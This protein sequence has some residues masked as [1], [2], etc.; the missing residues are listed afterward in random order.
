MAKRDL[1]GVGERKIYDFLGELEAELE[2]DLPFYP[3][4]YWVGR[5]ADFGALAKLGL[6]K[7]EVGEK[8]SRISYF[9]P[10]KRTVLLR[11]LD[12]EDMAEEAGH[13]VHWTLTPTKFPEKLNRRNV[14]LLMFSEAI[15]YFCS[16]L[17]VPERR[18]TFQGYKDLLLLPEEEAVLY[19]AKVFNVGK[20]HL[21]NFL[22]YQ[23]GYTLGEKMFRAYNR[24][25]I[26]PKDI[27]SLMKANI[28]ES[29]AIPFFMGLRQKFWPFDLNAAIKRMNIQLQ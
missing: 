15:G 28:S 8:N 13:F 20:V 19:I 11:N 21:L 27:V 7:E 26:G 3:E 25:E 29:E 10:S 1:H 14:F 18:N 22:K 5:N 9:V 16:K 17:I 2:M 24:H 12:Q 4:V 6:S 23:Q